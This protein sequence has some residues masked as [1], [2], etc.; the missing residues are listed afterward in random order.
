M[1]FRPVIVAIALECFCY[2]WAMTTLLIHNWEFGDYTFAGKSTAN[3]ILHLSGVGY[4]E[5]CCKKPHSSVKYEE[6]HSIDSC[7]TRK[8]FLFRLFI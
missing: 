5:N 3:K 6:S 7:N 2:L 8:C 1:S 4:L